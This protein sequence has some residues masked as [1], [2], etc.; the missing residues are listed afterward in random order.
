M[1]DFLSKGFRT[2]A[3]TVDYTRELIQ[4]D[5]IF[6]PRLPV[7]L[8][9]GTHTFRTVMLLDSGADISLIPFDVAE[10]LEMKLSEETKPNVAASG[11]FHVR[12]SAVEIW[13]ILNKKGYP[14][15]SVPVSVPEK[16][17]ERNEPEAEEDTNLNFPLLGR[18]PF[19][20]M[21]D[22]TFQESKL[23]VTFEPASKPFSRQNRGSSA[24]LK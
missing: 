2:L 15:G 18:K 10:V 6:R 13:L 7:R 16:L 1:I 5:P 22:I 3:F 12:T 19:F 9:N 14:L 8:Q 23:K 24:N 4:G 20:E 21:Y 11:L 17:P